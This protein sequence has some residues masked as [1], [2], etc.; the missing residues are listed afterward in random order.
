M[1]TPN[2]RG[3]F[4][5]QDQIN[6]NILNYHWTRLPLKEQHCNPVTH[7]SNKEPT[8]GIQGVGPWTL[9]FDL[10][11]REFLKIDMRHRAQRHGKRNKGHDMEK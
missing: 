1:K 3:P 10:S 5:F 7:F 11:R 4:F 8:C 9:K 6:N 2:G